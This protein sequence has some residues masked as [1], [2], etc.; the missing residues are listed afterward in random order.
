M[1]PKQRKTAPDAQN[2]DRALD[3]D[4]IIEAP[5]NIALDGFDLG[6]ALGI[7]PETE[8]RRPNLEEQGGIKVSHRMGSRQ[9]NRKNAPQV[10]WIISFADGCSCGDGT[11]Y[12]AANFVL[13]GIKPNKAFCLLPSGE[14]IHKMT[15]QSNPNQPRPELG[16]KTFYEITGGR[17]SFD[18]YVEA[19]GG[20]I[21]QGWQLRYI[22]FI[23]DKKWQQRLTVPEIPFSR[24]DELGAE[25]YKGQ[26]ITQAERHAASFYDT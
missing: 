8:E 21:M 6:A 4:D 11:I 24:I 22:Y 13:T 14:K 2:L 5:E 10:K 9:I 18:K 20:T 7:A 12:R 17:Y 3:D 1:P 19:V 26:H 23:I 15:L 25:M 16:G